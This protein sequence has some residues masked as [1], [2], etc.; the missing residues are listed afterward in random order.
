M[1]NNDK[2]CHPLVLVRGNLS[3]PINLNSYPNDIDPKKGRFIKVKS[4]LI[5]SGKNWPV[6]S[7]NQFKALVR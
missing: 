6:N 3:C 4:A 7:F 2:F 5:S 1:N